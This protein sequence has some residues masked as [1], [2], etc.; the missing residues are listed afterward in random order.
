MKIDESLVLRP[1][2]VL[3]LIPKMDSNIKNE[4]DRLKHKDLIYKLIDTINKFYVDNNIN[5]QISKEMYGTPN[6]RNN[7]VNNIIKQE[8]NK[9]QKL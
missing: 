3:N 8:I 7:W 2:T 5:W 4:D 9:S 6:S 1:D